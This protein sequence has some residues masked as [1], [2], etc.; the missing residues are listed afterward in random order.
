MLHSHAAILT[1]A[2]M[3]NRDVK[4]SEMTGDARI[5]FQAGEWHVHSQ[6]ESK[7]YRVNPSP[8][9]TACECEDFQ[10]RQ[11]ACKHVLAV[12]LLLDRQIK[13]DPLPDPATIPMRAPRP[14][15]KQ[16]WPSYNLAQTNEKDH[17]QVLL[18]DLCAG[19]PQPPSKGGLKGGRPALSLADSI[20]SAVFKVYALVS[21]RRFMSDLREAQERK[22]VG[23]LLAYNS[24]LATLEREDVTPILVDLIRQSSLPLAAV[25]SQFSVDS[26]GFSTCRYTKWFD[27]KYGSN[28]QKADWVKAHVC[29]GTKTQI[30]TAVFVD[31]KNSGDCPQFGPL[32]NTT[33]QGFTVKEISGDKAYL[34]NENLN[35]AEALGAVPFIPFKS[36]SLPGGS[37]LWRRMYFYFM[38]NRHEF[39][40]H[41]HRRS[42]IES[43]FSM[44][45]RKFG[46]SVRARTDTAMKNEVLAKILCHNL[47]CCISAWYELNIEPVMWAAPKLPDEPPDV[48]A[49]QQPV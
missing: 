46:D 3:D 33:A 21:A 18:A 44:I 12:R 43:A 19:V 35:I 47:C 37:E 49:L 9:A 1:G 7:Y 28:R 40:N 5:S 17:F 14:T 22:H 30:V 39:L 15:Y 10:L 36:N 48:L 2:A 45:K 42:N 26:S 4:A 31:E 13:G 8:T 34:S 6:T 38:V 24:V 32:L 27:E 20:F 29:I 25:E 16:D 41:Y 11:K 23:Q